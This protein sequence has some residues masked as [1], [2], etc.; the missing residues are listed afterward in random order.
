MSRSLS[1][2][3]LS[4]M[5]ALT[6]PAL[7]ATAVAQLEDGVHVD[8][9]SAPA[10]EYALPL[11]SARGTAGTSVSGESPKTPAGAPAGA[12]APAFGSGITPK[13]DS[14][15]SGSR[16]SGRSTRPNANRSGSGS[17]T[18][19][20]TGTGTSTSTSTSTD[21]TAEDR[22]VPTG[23]EAA[24]GNPLLYSLGGVLAV[25]VAGGLVALTLRR[26]QSP[27]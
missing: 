26:R 15:T 24:G 13:A 1:V 2:L 18:S 22:T 17:G 27:A 4:L 5:L 3:V 20:G 19:T 16:S 9:D 25:L 21:E 8:P 6:W 7:S 23:A 14:T 10:K 11:D 12:P